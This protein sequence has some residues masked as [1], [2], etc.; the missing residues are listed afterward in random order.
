[1]R[2]RRGGGG[3]CGE[4]GERECQETRRGHT[5]PDRGQQRE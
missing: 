4:D 3:V 5:V 2:S 1:M